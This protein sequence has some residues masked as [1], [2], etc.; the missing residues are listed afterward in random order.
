MCLSELRRNPPSSLEELRDTL[1]EFSMTLD[2]DEISKACR[3][4]FP[5]A[6]ACI[7]SA[8]GAFEYKLKKFKKRKRDLETEE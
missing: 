3:D 6:A 1:E 7:E 2:K 8:G 4:I 5:R